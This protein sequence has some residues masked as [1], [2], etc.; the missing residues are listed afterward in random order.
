M[1]WKNFDNVIW[2]RVRDKSMA[3]AKRNI[4][5]PIVCSD[6]NSG[7]ILVSKENARRAYV[8][9]HISFEECPLGAVTNLW[10]HKQLDLSSATILTN[11]PGVNRNPD[12]V[13]LHHFC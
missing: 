6:L 7:A 9:E 10:D 3:S 8:G 5:G 12:F 11:P 13:P 4:D 1:E 2:S